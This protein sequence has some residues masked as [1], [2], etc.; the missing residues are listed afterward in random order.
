MSA[1]QADKLKRDIQYDGYAFDRV[2]TQ[3]Q[4]GAVTG[5][6]NKH[7]GG[8][9]GRHAVLKWLFGKESS[10]LLTN[11]EW[12]ALMYWVGFWQDDAGEWQIS[13]D[14]PTEAAIAVAAATDS[15]PVN[16]LISKGGKPTVILDTQTKSLIN[17]FLETLEL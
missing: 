11:S 17:R 16:E 5:V 7:M 9:D 13:E 14:F 12:A 15:Y 3:R 10:K 4:K 2:L 6:M 8:S 1:R